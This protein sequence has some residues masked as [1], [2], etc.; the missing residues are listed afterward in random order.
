MAYV[1]VYHRWN[2]GNVKKYYA[3][4]EEEKDRYSRT[5]FKWS[6]HEIKFSI[7]NAV[8]YTYTGKYCMATTKKGLAGL[9]NVCSIS[10][11]FRFQAAIQFLLP[12]KNHLLQYLYHQLAISIC[13]YEGYSYA[14]TTTYVADRKLSQ[15]T[16]QILCKFPAPQN[17]DVNG[18]PL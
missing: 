17:D 4:P 10:I 2:S 18:N 8:L 6:S 15:A 5:N 13:M 3:P 1:R 7:A 14:R 12:W 16:L 11:V 9:L